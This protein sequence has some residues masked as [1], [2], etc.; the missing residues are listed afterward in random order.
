[1][2]LQEQISSLQWW[3]QADTLND[4]K[5]GYPINTDLCLQG[6]SKETEKVFCLE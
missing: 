2:H 5:H 4:R 1:M 3:K 6:I